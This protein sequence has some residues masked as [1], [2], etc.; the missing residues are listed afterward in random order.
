MKESE[1][2]E[3]PQAAA[4]VAKLPLVVAKLP[5][6]TRLTVAEKAATIKKENV[7]Y[8]H[9]R[10]ALLSLPNAFLSMHGYIFRHTLSLRRIWFGE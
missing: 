5:F 9:H 7:I 1:E 8:H 2:T 3:V 6:L 4:L 10:A